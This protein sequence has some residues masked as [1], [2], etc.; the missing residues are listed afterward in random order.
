MFT[1]LSLKL[2]LY[3][4]FPNTVVFFLYLLIHKVS[5]INSDTAPAYVGEK[6]SLYGSSI[7]IFSLYILI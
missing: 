4:V 6:F 7:D 1:Y 2:F 3:S 5:L